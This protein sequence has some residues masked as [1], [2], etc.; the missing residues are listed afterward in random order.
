[1]NSFLKLNTLDNH[2]NEYNYFLPP[3]KMLN[4]ELCKNNILTYMI[5]ETFKFIINIYTLF[6]TK[7]NTIHKHNIILLCLN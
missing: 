1:M 5:T 7:I 4:D 3:R 6:N 2:N